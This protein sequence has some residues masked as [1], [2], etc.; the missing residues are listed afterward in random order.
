[1]DDRYLWDRSGSADPEIEELEKLLAPLAHRGSPPALPRRPRF[2]MGVLLSIAAAVVLAA[3]AVWIARAA[4]GA[5]WQVVRMEGKPVV[6]LR[7]V[8]TAGRLAVGE[9]LVTDDASRARIAVGSI[10]HVD[11][12][13]NSR[14]RLV[15]ASPTNHRLAL[16][17]G[18]IQARIWAPPRLF[19]VETASA[20][21]VDLGCVYTLRVDEKGSGVLSVTTGWVELDGPRNESLVPA[22]ASCRTKAGS[23]PGTPFYDDASPAFR[24]ALEELDFGDGR[25]VALDAVLAESRPRDALTL[26]HLLLRTDGAEQKRVYDRLSSLV[27]PPA[28]VTREGIAR[29][30]DRMLELWRDQ[31]ELPWFQKDVPWWRKAWHRIWAP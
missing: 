30:D 6:G 5:P 26:W 21:A 12:E 7:P 1:M 13:P 9:R 27:P 3:G 16:E 17:R 2:P 8:E 20:L 11:V 22:G 10:G 28:G 29:R 14:L 23:G 25:G 19:F 31:L 18:G 24:R 4:S 15:K